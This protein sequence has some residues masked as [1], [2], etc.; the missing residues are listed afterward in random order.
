MQSGGLGRSA[1]HQIEHLATCPPLNATTMALDTTTK[2]FQNTPEYLA[3]HCRLL[4]YKIEAKDF[5][6]NEEWYVRQGYEVI[7]RSKSGYT[8]ADPRTGAV[9]VIPCVYLK[10]DIV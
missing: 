9:E 1:M 8:W 3:Y 7:S 2:E 6:S 4:G 5:R 10:K